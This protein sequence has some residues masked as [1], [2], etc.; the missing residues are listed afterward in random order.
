MLFQKTPQ[1]QP[2]Y[3]QPLTGLTHVLTTT[4]H[5]GRQFTIEC[6]IHEGQV[7]GWKQIISLRKVQYPSRIPVIQVTNA[8]FDFFIYTLESVRRLRKTDEFQIAQKHLNFLGTL[9]RISGLVFITHQ[10]SK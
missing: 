6:R 3:I 9:S 1:E 8:D 2:S 4:D 7:R 10:H 5:N